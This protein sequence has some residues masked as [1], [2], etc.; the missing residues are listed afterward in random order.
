MKLSIDKRTPWLIL[1]ISIGFA[2]IYAIILTKTYILG[3]INPLSLKSIIVVFLYSFLMVL[4][5][6][7]ILLISIWIAITIHVLSKDLHFVDNCL[8]FYIKKYSLYFGWMLAIVFLV[9]V[10]ALLILMVS[11]FFGSAEDFVSIT[12]KYGFTLFISLAVSIFIF[13]L[14]IHAHLIEPPK[15][16]SSLANEVSSESMASDPES[17]IRKAFIFFENSLKNKAGPALLEADDK[18]SNLIGRVYN[19]NGTLTH[20]KQEFVSSLMKGAYGLYRNDL[21]HNDKKYSLQQAHY[22]LMLVDDLVRRLDESELRSPDSPN[23]NSV[24]S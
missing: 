18:V 2:I 16:L 5:N 1:Y 20:E 19:K 3:E 8:A 9:F 23:N 17:A 11:L 14:W 24:T 22:I 12:K 4:G 10:I 13:I 6:T 7:F 21:A 15:L